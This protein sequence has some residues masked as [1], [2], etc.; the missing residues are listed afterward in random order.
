VLIAFVIIPSMMNRSRETA[1]IVRVREV[2]VPYTLVEEDML[3]M[4]EVGAYNLPLDIISDKSLVV[5]KYASMEILPGD[6]LF[7]EK[8]ALREQLERGFLYG[9]GGYIGDGDYD[10][11]MLPAN[12]A[13]TITLRSHAA[14]IAGELRAGD[15]VAALVYMQDGET[16]EHGIVDLPEL[17][18]LEILAVYRSSIADSG[19]IRNV[20][21]KVN[22]E[23][24]R[25]LIEAE[26]EGVIHLIF[27]ERS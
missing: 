15:V 2:V 5:G 16:G 6:N 13:V 12:L 21:F 3:E 11:G 19:E 27:L 8:F 26:N 23:Q 18:N 17:L 24:A 10:D 9:V 20:T 4:V 25:T 22:Y 14:G 7:V 1:F